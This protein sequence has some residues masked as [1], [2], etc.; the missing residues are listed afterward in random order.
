MKK[1]LVAI[2]T[3]INVGLLS[4]VFYQQH[5]LKKQKFNKNLPTKN[6]AVFTPAT[7][8]SLQAIEDG[9]RKTM[10]QDNK[11][12]YAITTYNANGNRTLMRSQ[13]EEIA[14]SNCDL[15]FTIGAQATQMTKEITE[16]K[17]IKIP[18]VFAA[19]SGP[20]DLKLIQSYDSSGNNLTGISED[21]NFKKQVDILHYLKPTIK[22]VTLVYNPS[23]G[24]GLEN[25]KN[26][27]DQL[28]EKK[29][30]QLST[31]EVYHSNEIYQKASSAISN[32]DVVMVL[33]DNTVV[34]AIDSLIKLCNQHGVL[35][36]ASDLDS[37]DKGAAAAFGVQEK[38][39]GIGSA[40]KALIIL[41]KGKKATQIPITH[42][43]GFTLKVNTKTMNQQ[44]LKLDANQ[45][46][47]MR[48]CE[49][50]D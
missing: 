2:S 9:F 38:N 12:N 18:V 24:S 22:H 17:R 36:Y 11:A 10:K 31:L 6:I 33:K 32:T 1:L 30:I 49:V 29:G 48:S 47:L 25:Q 14:Q 23:E 42:A 7:H 34:S 4:L 35:L 16:K 3:I 26:E 19:V 50:I 21:R 8:P 40:E 44:G 13:A 37:V 39:Y 46:F 45:L 5:K 15:I 43:K 27:I 28:L 41:N 20:K